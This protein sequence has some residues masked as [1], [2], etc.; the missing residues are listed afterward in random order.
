MNRRN[1]I[2]FSILA[3]CTPTL[4]KAN[5]YKAL[6]LP[7]NCILCGYCVLDCPVNAIYFEKIERDL[8]LVYEDACIGCNGN[9][10]DKKAPCQDVCPTD[11][12][13]LT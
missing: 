8:F 1:F 13:I 5:T 3:V 11:A 4:L 7:Y 10:D 9:D 2:K 6:I 12:I